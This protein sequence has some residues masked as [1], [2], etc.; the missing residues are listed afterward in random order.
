MARV[1]AK[2]KLI[3]LIVKKHGISPRHIEKH[4]HTECII[5]RDEDK[6]DILYEDTA[7]TIALRFISLYRSTSI[8][9]WEGHYRAL[10]QG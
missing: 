7:D 6:K 3:D 1:R 8:K 5:L 4:P 9:A 10:T 2:Y